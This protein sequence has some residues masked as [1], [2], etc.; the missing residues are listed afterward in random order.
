VIPKLQFLEPAKRFKAFSTD[1]PVKRCKKAESPG[2]F[3]GRN[4][5]NDSPR[6]RAAGILPAEPQPAAS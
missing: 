2:F 4:G 3:H 1:L 5:R 6:R